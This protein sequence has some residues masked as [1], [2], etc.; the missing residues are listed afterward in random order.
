MSNVPRPRLWVHRTGWKHHA[1]NISGTF[2]HKK[3][4]FHTFRQVQPHFLFMNIFSLGSM[5]G[6]QHPLWKFGTL[7]ISPKLSQL[8]SPKFHKHLGSVKYSFPM[9]KFFRYG[10]CQGCSTPNV[11]LGPHHISKTIK[12]G[13]VEILHTLWQ[14]QTLI[15]GCEN[16]SQ[17]AS[18]GRSAP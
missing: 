9:W 11:N 14:G 16:F 10:A 6:A 7:F 5:Q 2:R 1:L 12:S 3:L 4:K 17:G 8:E 13:K 15:L 18:Q